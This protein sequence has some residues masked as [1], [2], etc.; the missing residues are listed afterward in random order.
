MIKKSFISLIILFASYPLSAESLFLTDGSIIKGNVISETASEVS[1]R[2]EQKK[3]VRYPRR[4]VM[5]V[6]YTELDMSKIY[7][8]KKNGENMKVYRVDEDRETYTFRNEIN[9]PEEFLVKRDDVLFVAARNP[10]GLKGKPGYTDIDLEWYLPY[11]KMEYFNIYY[12]KKKEDKYSI[13]GR[14]NTNKFQMKE[15]SGNTKYLFIITGVDDTADETSPSNEIQISTLNSEPSAPAGLKV[16]SSEKGGAIVKWKAAQD[17]DGAVV[18]YRIY[19]IK[20]DKKEIAGE[21]SETSFT[22]SDM[23]AVD[24]VMVTAVDDGGAESGKPIESSGLYI[25]PAAIYPI[26]SFSDLGGI[27]YGGMMSFMANDFFFN[28]FTAGLESGYFYIPGKNSI[29]TSGQNIHR[30]HLVTAG[31][32]TGYK[33]KF[34]ENLFFM[35]AITLGGAYY[36]L[37]YTSRD[38]LTL[39]DTEKSSKNL[40]PIAA[41]SLSID[42]N[43][44]DSFFMGLSTRYGVLI[45]KSKLFQFASCEINFGMRFYP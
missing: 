30:F 1:F 24:N 9:K 11:D 13:A 27:G 40:D 3:V 41:G 5:R 7:V 12:K 19:I 22:V 39:A 45:E 16:V 43:I 35:P 17:S 21:T 23:S 26:G 33:F 25:S 29:Q 44:S 15:L 37:S 10:S 18:K 31:V 28:G 6:L 20:N 32:K 14:A 38:I 36:D 42:Y 4:R 8:Q 34:T 2:D